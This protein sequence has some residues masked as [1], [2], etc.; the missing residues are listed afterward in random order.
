MDLKYTNT[1]LDDFIKN[2]YFEEIENNGGGMNVNDMFSFYFLLKKLQP[3]IIIESGI[4]NG[5]STKLIRVVLGKNIKIICLDPRDIPKDIGYLDNNINTIYYT[6]KSFID[7]SDLKLENVNLNEILCF[8]DDHQNSAQRVL[9]CIEKGIKHI[10]FNDNYP[11][12]AGSHYSIQHLID[13]D[14]R[15]NFDLN[16]Q[17]SYSINVLPQ[18]DLNK[19][20]YILEKI[21]N[22]TVFPNIFSS[23][24]ILYEG[25]FYSEGF[26]ENND[27]NNIEK[28]NIFF[29]NKDTYCWNTYLT[30]KNLSD[31]KSI[32]LPNIEVNDIY[33]FLIHIVSNI[34]HVNFIPNNIYLDLNNHKFSIEILSLLYPNSKIINI[35]ECPSNC[36]SILYDKSQIKNEDYI[37]LKKIFL[38]YIIN[39]KLNKKYSKY[40]YISREDA[41]YRKIINEDML[42]NYLEKKG[43]EKIV[44][45]KL[46]LLDQMTIFYNASII[47][48][49]H[50]VQLTNILFCN[51]N[52]KIIEIV[53]KKMS[54]LLH[55]EDIAKTFNLNY[56]RYTSVI[57]TITDSY[58]SDLVV[59]NIE[60]F[61]RYLENNI[62]ISLCIPT[63]NRFDIFL[64]KYLEEYIKYLENGL[65]NEIIISD[66]D[67]ND[68]NKIINK[69]QN[70]LQKNNNFKVYKNNEILGVFLNKLKVCSYAT[71]NYIA[72]IDSDNFCEES[73]FIKV[74]D[75]ILKTNNLSKNLILSPSYSKPR[76]SYKSLENIILT[77]DNINQY[78][79]YDN[80]GILINTGNY[81][82]TKNI[83][84]NI[85]YDISI[86]SNIS[87]C[88]VQYFN[89]LVFKQFEDFQ[90]HIVKDL[91][92][93]HIVH[94]DSE[95]LKT[96]KKC[97][98]YAN[99]YV[100]NE[101]YKL[102]KYVIFRKSGR[103]GNALFRYL[104]SVLFC[105]K[106]DYDYILEDE[107][108]QIKDY[109]FYKG[110]DQCDY[111]IDYNNTNIDNLKN[112]CNENDNALC[113][114]T[115]GFIKSDYN[116]DNL[117]SNDYINEDNNQGLYVKNIMNINDNNYFKNYEKC[118]INNLI[119]DGYF[120]FDEIYLEN[121]N[122]II[123]F[124]EKNKDNHKIKTD[125]NDIFYLKDLINNIK[126]DN[127]KIYDI[128]IHLRLDDFDRLD[129]FIEYNCIISL[130]KKIYTNNKNKRYA[131]V[132]QKIHNNNYKDNEYI[133]NLLN[134]FKQNNIEINVENNDLI[135]DFNIMKQC[136]TLVC[137]N[138]TLSWIAGYLSKNIELCYMPLNDNHSNRFKKPI[139]NTIFYDTSIQKNCYICGCVLNCE[140]YLKN[141]FKNI[142]KIGKLFDNY[143]V[144]IAYDDSTDNSLNVL[145][146][147]K[148]ELYN[149]CQFEI[150]INNNK[151]SQYKTENIS[152]AR[153][154]ILNFIRSD[155]NDDYNYFIIMDLD[156]VCEKEID[157]SILDKNLKNN[158]WDSLSFN[159][160]DYYDIWALSIKP[161]VTSCWNWHE[162]QMDSSFVIDIMK[163]HISTALN[164]LNENDL[165]QCYSAFNGFAIYKKDKFINCEYSNNIF[166]SHG[167][168]NNNL[169][170]ENLNELNK[171]TGKN[172]SLHMN[173]LEDCEHRYFHLSAIKKNNAKIMISP[174]YLFNEEKYEEHK[175]VYVSSRGILK[176]CDIKSITPISS[177][178][179]LINYDFTKLF[180]GCTLYVCN[181]AIP[182]FSTMID[183]INCKFILVSGDSDCTVPD[184]LFKSNDDFNN[185]INNEKLIHWYSQNCVLNHPKISRIPIGLDYHTMS[186][187]DSDWGEKISS[188]VQENIL[189]NVK[190]C[191]KPF[192]EREI[193]CYANFHFSTN[194]KYGSDRIDA[195]NY[196]NK[197]LV[198]YEN[199]KVNRKQTWENQSKYAFVIS[200]HGNGLDCHRT[201]EALCL[202]CIPIVKKS[203]ISEDLFYDLPVL[204]ID[205]WKDVTINL[206]N[207]T[208]DEFK[209]TYF[210]Y[211]KLTLKYWNNIINKK[212]ENI[213]PK[214]IYQT[215]KT[216]ELPIEVKKIQEKIISINPGYKIELYDDNDIDYFIKNNFDNNIYNAYNKLNVGAAKADLWRYLILYKYGGIYLDID[217]NILKP[218]DLIIKEDDIAII[219]R[220][221][222][223]SNFLQW[224][225]IFSKNHPILKDVIDNCIYNI[226]NETTEFI[227]DLT[228]PGVFTKSI[229]NVMLD[230][231]NKKNINLY[232]EK[233]EDLNNYI[234]NINNSIRCRFYG[235]D[236]NNHASWI[237]EYK[238]LLYN[239]NIYWRNEKKIFKRDSDYTK[240]FTNIYENCLWGSNNNENYRG[241]S[242]GGSEINY[243]I[244]TYIPFL[245]KFINNY[246]IKTIVDLGCG[247]FRC[248]K[249]IYDDLNILYNGYDIYEKIIENNKKN[250]SKNKYKFFNIDFLNKKETIISTDLCI[251]KDVLQHW[252]LDDI[253]IFMDYLIS[254]QKFKYILLCNCSYQTEDNTDINVGDFRSLSSNYLPL[255][256]YNPITLYKY[257]TKE[258]C[259]ID[260]INNN[261]I[262]NLFESDNYLDY[263]KVYHYDKKIRLGINHD[264][265]YIIGEH[266]IKYDCY[267][268]AG[269]SIEESFSKDFINK[270]NFNINN[271]YGFD[272]TIDNYPYE[273]TNKITFIKKNINKFNDNNNTNLIDLIEKYNNIFLK[274]D[275]EG[276]EYEWLSIITEDNLKRFS[277]IVI[278][279]H[280]INDD[281]WN[282]KHIDK[283]N[284]FKKLFN[285]HYIIHAHGN[286]NGYTKNN[287]P[288]VI[289]LTYINKNLFYEE[290]E[291]N[292]NKLPIENLD[293]PNCL[294]YNDL[295]L[296]FFPFV[297]II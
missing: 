283:I 139:E 200:P 223:P 181:Y 13:N 217:S 30:L 250:F 163:D 129:D 284:C 297:K 25:I 159:R 237:H 271:S 282:C 232:Y 191:A 45:S 135:T 272:G 108:S 274:M 37:Y 240:I 263:L 224:L 290:L 219:S 76:F 118:K 188:D 210:N 194:T 196:I 145:Y 234:N 229:N 132:F 71:N 183:Q 47:V 85:K 100:Y 116:I 81:I 102:K 281:S 51:D 50:G 101:I 88:D 173:L 164:N 127:S 148:N 123:N 110:V 124:I 19:R 54:N 114:N 238:D 295:N 249:Y 120:Q 60:S 83:I 87:A 255:K 98:E 6:G 134:W 125:R 48:S 215:W 117:S 266:N 32:F 176:S 126:L 216:K 288:D 287:I 55:F 222:G 80:F 226:M 218:L 280:G 20:N 131:L 174:Q 146:Q 8:F 286:N 156:N 107:C 24:I 149:I 35:K 178:N 5:F 184:E 9:Q 3:K 14:L 270:Y 29:K 204:I 252:K 36:L 227:V 190:E 1:D 162:T 130:L 242:G 137:S 193:K 154:S 277:Q 92:Y 265:G 296:N 57:E 58:D 201:W 4:W 43:F 49:I 128:V 119:M 165:L 46:T 158:N 294:K 68:Y 16:N 52:V 161:F 15:K 291:L 235:I 212:S 203:G 258:I 211:E 72:L 12:N 260:L 89:L 122:E 279:F 143:K 195:M 208:I 225:M 172:N 18:I 77:K 41:N 187:K 27:I 254:S 63:K 23:E 268:S 264:G 233:D 113:F 105:I 61:E 206:L 273:Y 99:K 96:I 262:N 209:N 31:E 53:S 109:I 155:N 275:I 171:I 10:F 66:E 69:Y 97:S 197:E 246:N 179:T 221:G 42:F 244:N 292:I 167:L 198:F 285:T 141:V 70:I 257:D 289:E 2:I 140:K 243:N 28:Y 22:Y 251:I 106:Y 177:I 142:T 192:W 21:D 182:Y 245:K 236:Y 239:N 278:E 91:E 67:G 104:A 112:I 180:D 17:Y 269:I 84:D 33:Q 136:K 231:Y 26:F 144:I 151:L 205:H 169:I 74:R 166:K 261:K 103:L 207:N 213:I 95:Y 253:Y 170:Q 241:S 64:N 75:Y 121:K 220:E 175:C 93:I 59:L 230:F 7:F 276:F 38:P 78:T 133:N 65:I 189:N 94:N 202:G 228:G 39:N 40:I 34:R 11:L 111:D 256:K 62:K 82:I 152:N 199:T 115:L 185:F 73:Y 157:I 138:S 259:L 150:I 293:Y 153:N 86:L 56:M 147:L 267:I 248:G 214:I 90:F 247:D 168:I 79:E 186:E 160:K 44:M